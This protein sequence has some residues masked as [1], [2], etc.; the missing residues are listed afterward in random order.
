MGL[1]LGHGNAVQMLRVEHDAQEK[2]EGR[3]RGTG[4]RN[5]DEMQRVESRDGGRIQNKTVGWRRELIRKGGFQQMRFR[6]IP[7]FQ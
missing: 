1:G 3:E 2:G 5:H 6:T 4:A 7:K